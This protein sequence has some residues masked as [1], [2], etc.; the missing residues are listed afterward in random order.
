MQA[1]FHSFFIINVPKLQSITHLYKAKIFPCAPF[2]ILSQLLQWPFLCPWTI[3]TVPHSYPFQT[4][5]Q[6]PFFHS[7]SLQT[8]F[9]VGI[10]L[11]PSHFLCHTFLY[12]SVS[13]YPMGFL[14]GQQG[15]MECKNLTPEII[16]LLFRM[17]SLSA[18]P[19]SPDHK[20]SLRS[21]ANFN[22]EI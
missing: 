7:S 8:H 12:I 3:V 4:V 18:S 19:V 9:C 17:Q 15:E 10:L 21:A 16:R 5:L 6:R 11:P 14:L 20:T 1:K 13:G 22:V 2:T